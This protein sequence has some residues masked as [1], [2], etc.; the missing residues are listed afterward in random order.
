M[1]TRLGKYRLRK[2]KEFILLRSVEAAIKEQGLKD[3][4]IL[5]ERI[6]PDLTNQYS[7]AKIDTPYLT[8]KARGLHA[9]QVTLAGR[10]IEK[11]KRL[12]VVDIGDSAGTHLQ[13]ITKMQPKGREIKCLSVNS[14]ERAVERIK[15]KGL[16][17]VC[18]KAED[19]AQYNINAD[20]FMCFEM[21]EHLMNPCFFLHE[22]S[23]K[24]NAEY[25]VVTVPFLRKSRI[26]LHHLR[27]GRKEDVC[28]EN[29]HLFELSPEDWK[30]IIRHSGWD[31]VMEDYYFQYPRRSFLS[32]TRPLWRR[33]DF[34]GFYGLIL[35]RDSAWSSLY[36]DW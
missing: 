5:L 21:L 28:A 13:Y 10:I 34:E 2:I 27:A 6:V 26:G 35:R 8:R 29:T 24:T 16:D 19:L 4:L 30:L 22:L 12:T 1:Q 36:K 25:L 3:M 7:A 23:S 15:E 9:F 14:D 33:Y 11:Y 17:A 20:I 32:I 31:I 18:A